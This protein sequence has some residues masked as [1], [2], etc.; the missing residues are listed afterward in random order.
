MSRIAYVN[1]RYVPHNQAMVHVEDRG[2]QFADGVYEVC[3][4]R[5][6]MLLDMTRHLDRLERSLSELQIRM[7]VARH[8]FPTLLRE[9]ARRNRVSNGMVYLQVNRGVT[10]RNHLFPPS[11][12]K[13]SL[14]ITARNVNRQKAEATAKNGIA[15]I[16]VPDNRW[17]R[18]DIKA[19]GLLPNVMAKQAAHE[20]GAGEAWFVDGEGFVT[21]GSSTNAW[22]VSKEGTLITRACESGILRG[23]TRSRVMDM[24]AQLGIKVEERAFTADE[25]K[26]ARESFVTAAT[27]VV[28]PV[29]EVDGSA[30]AN[31][32]PGE[33][34]TRLRALFFET[35]EKLPC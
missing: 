25:A 30:V 14:V 27:S 21:E 9:V 22:I 18:V 8:I 10:P 28:M 7:P 24:A 4:V 6:H 33:I 13:P 2:F 16:T 35:S 5:L 17:E 15:V 32:H 29:V 31:G 12:V 3:E 20:A 26:N 1:G 19:I 23:I 34:A 11:S